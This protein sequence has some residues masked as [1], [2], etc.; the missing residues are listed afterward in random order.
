M[1]LRKL[2]RTAF[3]YKAQFISMIIMV[4]I[5]I[6]VFV[7]FN[8]EWYT[9]E[10][11][12]GAF[13][14]DTDYADYRLY[15][16]NGF[17]QSDIE[18]IKNIQEVKEA[19]RVFN[20]NVDVKDEEKSLALFALEDYCVSTM[21]I[22]SGKDY[23]ENSDGFWLSDKYAYANGITIGDTLT[24][25]YRNAQISG[26][27]VG[28][29]KSSEF[30]I[31]VADANQLISDFTSFGF[32]YASPSKVF[33]EMGFS[34]Y[35]QINLISD[36]EKT[37]MEKAVTNALGKTTLVLSKEEHVSYAAALSEVEEGQTMVSV[38]PI[39]FLLIG[40]LTMITTMHRIT[41]NEKTQIGTLK[42][43]GFKNGKIIRH[44]T[45]YGLFIG[46]VGAIV[47][48][49][50]G[51]GICALV[52]NPN[53]MQGSYFDM[54]DWTL[55]APWWNWLIL[56][57]VIA[58]LTF[59]SFLSVRKML[60]GTAA[61]ALRPYTP[62]KVKALA[63]EKTKAWENLPFGTKWNLRDVFRHKTRSAMTLIGVIGCMLLLVG[64]LGMRD[65]MTEFLN[66]LD[67]H[68]LNY[69]TRVNFTETA[70]KEQALEFA[71]KYDG[72]FVA[73]SS[74][75][76]DGEAVALEIYGIERDS[77][78]FN[79]ADGKEVKLTRDGAYICIRLANKG[80]KVGDE[81]TFSPYGSDTSYKVKVVGVLRSFQSQSI[82]MTD[83]YA[84]SVGIDY[85]ISSV[86]L[87]IS[88][89]A[90][91]PED[92]ISG[93]QTKASIMESYSSF[94]QIM[95]V[96]VLVFVLAAVILGVVVLYNLGVMSYV[97]RSRELATLKVVGFKNKRIGRILVSQNIWITVIGIIIGLPLGVGVLHLLI[98]MLASEY[99]LK[100]ALGALTYCVS[101]LLTFGVSLL[102]GVFVARKN[103]KIDMVEAL[104]GTFGE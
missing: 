27:V 96:M 15:S 41:A 43:L 21:Y 50:I 32:V 6:G 70:T 102:V 24:L 61:D 19:S 5:G 91:K 82:I 48:I 68:S 94:M 18:A 7:G 66:T 97:E 80:V 17:S 28:L 87:N 78:R 64:G 98:T 58:F 67:N 12:T 77:V 100:M 73:T 95:N 25:T 74:V 86:F 72:D 57:A 47:G 45:A 11:N 8:M 42:A 22:V 55:R 59:I 63:I 65:T 31:C 49:A 62:K 10:N 16:E 76:L 56:A 54:P 35:P 92:F 23:D 79:G 3:K 53:G 88:P 37:D 46:V 1:L 9:L 81:I 29:V 38:L 2:F 69:Q 13:M 30:M 83:E 4:A 34:F 33:K 20:V 103:K 52:V 44:Y 99:E 75:Q 101:V 51:Y 60:N 104:K 93:T 14:S 84:R 40:V 39:L 89:D 71:D 26:E 36:M 90:I 85:R